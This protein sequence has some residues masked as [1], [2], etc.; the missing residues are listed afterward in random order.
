MRHL[1]FLVYVFI[2]ASCQKTSQ[3]SG[4]GSGGDTLTTTPVPVPAPGPSLKVTVTTVGGQPGKVEAVDGNGGNAHFLNPYKLCYDP[5]NKLLYVADRNYL[6]VID[7]QNNVSTLL[8]NGVLSNFDEILDIDLA[9]GAPGSLYFTTKYTTLYKIDG[10][11]NT[12]T[13]LT[14]GEGNSDG[15]LTTHD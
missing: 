12:L 14:Q 9:P 10:S 2:C 3:A 11:N 8:G 5:R 6:R 7:A 4:A 1:F 13:I 15:P